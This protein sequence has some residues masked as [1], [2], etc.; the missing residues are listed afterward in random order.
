MENKLEEIRREQL[1]FA[2]A[3]YP[4]VRE[5][6]IGA[7]ERYVTQR[8]SPGGFLTAVLSNDLREAQGRADDYNARTLNAIVGLCYTGL[9]SECWGS[10]ERVR[11]WLQ[12]EDSE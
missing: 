1:A 8:I 4:A 11:N 12:G 3:A 7:L 10:S 6:M 5:D 2:A 9:P